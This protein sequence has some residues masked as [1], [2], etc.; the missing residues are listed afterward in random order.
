[1]KNFRLSLLVLPAILLCSCNIFSNAKK[2][3]EKEIEVF[4]IDTIKSGDRLSS[5][6]SMMVKARFVEGED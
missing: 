1:M 3:Y 2:T 5:A 6:S 4:D